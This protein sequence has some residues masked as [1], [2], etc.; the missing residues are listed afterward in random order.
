MHSVAR[1]H[2]GP[3]W[4]LS[5][6]AVPPAVIIAILSAPV[7]MLLFMRYRKKQAAKQD[8]QAKDGEPV[9]TCKRICIHRWKLGR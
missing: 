5:A 8:A 1:A 3:S 2:I 7:W 6:P 4:V 9:H